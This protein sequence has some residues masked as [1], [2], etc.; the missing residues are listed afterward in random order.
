[1]KKTLDQMR[2]GDILVRGGELLW[3]QNKKLDEITRL[4]SKLVEI[5]EQ[6]FKMKWGEDFLPAVYTTTATT[7]GSNSLVSRGS[8]NKTVLPK[9]E[10]EKGGGK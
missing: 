8:P 5:E 10:E 6:N 1:M 4:L 7:A 2:G 3:L 9:N